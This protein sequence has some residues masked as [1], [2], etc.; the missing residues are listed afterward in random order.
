MTKVSEHV[1]EEFLVNILP[2]WQNT[3]TSPHQTNNKIVSRKQNMV[4]L[5]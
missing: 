1:E 2:N 5:V 4:W 3:V